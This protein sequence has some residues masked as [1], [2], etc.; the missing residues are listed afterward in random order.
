[1]S[2][3]VA[4]ASF[5]A[6]LTDAAANVISATNNGIIVGADTTNPSFTTTAAPP[7]A[8]TVTSQKFYTEDDLARVREQE[9][10]KLYPQIETLKEKLD[11][12][13]K[14]RDERIALEETARK[15]A[16]DQ[17]RRKAEEEMDVRS[18][19]EQKER[20]W[21][22]RLDQERSERENALA[23][24]DR[25]RQ[26]QE[27]SEYRMARLDEER[28]NIIPELLD[29]VTGSNPDEI[30]ASIAGLRERS[31]R[32]LDS[33]QQ[34]MQA[35]RRDMS[36][37]RVTAPAAGPLDTNSD[38]QSF[39]AEQIASMPFNE[40]VKHRSKLLGQASANRN[41]GLFG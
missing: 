4:Q 1:M 5:D 11:R 8:Q 18:L 16:E 23:L 29:L 17:A 3:T 32:I 22:E 15:D 13:E 33:A 12:L 28:D 41:Q 14:E 30:E 20:E 38:N 40:Y 37:A 27:V 34:A 21:T 36:G 35:A 2:E 39:S 25:E 31:S 10:G 7:V 19:L 24:L 26:F 6:G 9:K